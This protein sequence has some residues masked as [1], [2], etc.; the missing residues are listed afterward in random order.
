MDQVRTKMTEKKRKKKRGLLDSSDFYIDVILLL[1]D[2]N[3]P[4]V[5]PR[6]LW[7]DR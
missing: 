7:R 5:S 6:W 2:I 4:E 1:E 3:R